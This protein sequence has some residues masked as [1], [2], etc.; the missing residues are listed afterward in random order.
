[1][2]SSSEYQGMR[3]FKCDLHMHTPANARDWRGESM[4][5]DPAESARRYVRK[6][7]EERLECIAVTE[8]NFMAKTFLPYLRDA[9][10]ELKS[11]FDYEIVLFPGF[12]FTADVGRGMH[13][14]SLFEQGA[15]L[16]EI[17]HILTNC[18][19]PMPRQKPDGS[20]LPSEKRLPDIIREVQKCNE[21][22]ELKGIVI[23][24]HP[25]ETGIFDND[26][27]SEW[28]QQQE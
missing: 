27:I 21:N 22:G 12:E 10:E 17:D 15:D 28:L 14:L 26:R 13:V 20:F 11:E 8:H 23:C 9:I 2:K 24:P 16:D 7:Y 1:M 19:V 6:C 3:W 25:Y 5:G 18:G 4:G